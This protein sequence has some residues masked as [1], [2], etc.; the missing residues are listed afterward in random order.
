[1]PLTPDGSRMMTEREIES[2][3]IAARHADFDTR[4]KTAIAA[5][6]PSIQQRLATLRAER[7]AGV[8]Q[9][10]TIDDYRGA[11]AAAASEKVRGEEPKGH[12]GHATDRYIGPR[13]NGH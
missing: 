10:D 3:E 8:S 5:Q 2:A 1:M 11:D 6:P 4:L 7:E 13:T 12:M 9:E